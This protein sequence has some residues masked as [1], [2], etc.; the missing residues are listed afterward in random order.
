MLREIGPIP[1]YLDAPEPDLFGGPIIGTAVISPY[2]NLII[3][4]PNNELTQRLKHLTEVDQIVGISVGVQ[5]RV[6]KPIEN[7]EK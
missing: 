6:V 5:Y 1:V 7:E 3:S 2:G 4:I